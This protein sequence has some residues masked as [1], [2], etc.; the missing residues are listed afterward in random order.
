MTSKE[1]KLSLI[2]KGQVT[3]QQILH[4]MFPV[5][6]EEKNWQKF[7]KFQILAAVVLDQHVGTKTLLIEIYITRST[8]LLPNFHVR[9]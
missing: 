8:I 5:F 6:V 3:L 1:P 4:V 9:V 2:T 7:C